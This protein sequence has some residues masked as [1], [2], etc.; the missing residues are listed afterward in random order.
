MYEGSDSGVARRPNSTRRFR[1][2]LV[3][4]LLAISGILMGASAASAVVVYDNVPSPLPGNVISEAF[5]ATQTSEFGGEI[6]LAGTQRQDPTITVTMSSWGCQSAPSGVCTTTPGATFS[7]PITLNLYGVLPSGEPGSLIASVTQ[8]F[9]IPFRPSA[10]A[11]CA[12]PNQWSPDAG[13]NCFNGLANNIAFDLTGRG[14]SLPDKVIVALAYPT[15]NYGKPAIGPQPCTSTPQ[16]CGYDSLNVGLV[17][18]PTVGSLPRVDDAYL[19][20]IT[21]GQY[22]DGGT[23]G[24]D[25]LRLDAGCW[26]DSAPGAGDEQPAVEVNA[27]STAGAEG[28]SGPTGPTGPTGQTG[29]SGGVAGA[30]GTSKKCKKKSKKSASAAKK[31]KKKKRK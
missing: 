25:T 9:A 13:A 11:A 20:S 1:K 30:V 15:S 5:Q 6:Q 22:C 10:N 28:P 3:A 23:D 12:N 2:S 31:C 4:L 8:T 7:H 26:F 27:T 14:I 29:T 16:G 18:P 17:G 21:G 24:T 19:D